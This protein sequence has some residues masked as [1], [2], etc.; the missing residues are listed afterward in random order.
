[1]HP[2]TTLPTEQISLLL[3]A[4]SCRFHHPMASHPTIQ[5]IF[6]LEW[7]QQKTNTINWCP[8]RFQ[9][10]MSTWYDKNWLSF[11]LPDAFTAAARSSAAFFS[12]SVSS[13]NK[14]TSSSSSSSASAAFVSETGGVATASSDT[15]EDSTVTPDPSPETPLQT[16]NSI[17][18]W[19]SYITHNKYNLLNY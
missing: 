8:T 13:P 16:Q 4:S 2:R 11:F 14:S 9:Q 5:M 1:M 19:K 10:I 15:R 3:R 6:H 12:S 7:N 18:I 17:K